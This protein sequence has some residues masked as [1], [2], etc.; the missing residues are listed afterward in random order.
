MR[1]TPLKRRKR[2]RRMSE[3]AIR[4]RDLDALCR[5]VVMLRDRGMC[6]RCWSAKKIRNSE[7]IQWAHVYSRRFKSLRWNPM[8]SMALCAGCH[9]FWHHQPVAAAAWWV[10]HF[11]EQVDI[12]LRYTLTRGGKLDRM[13]TKLWLESELKR[14]SRGA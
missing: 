2:I 13:A 11:G 1:R 9:L 14:L 4:D 12:A 8:N 3:A 5:K 7:N 10:G 6:V